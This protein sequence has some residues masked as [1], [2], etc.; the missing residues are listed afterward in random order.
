M[1]DTTIDRNFVIRSLDILEGYK[2]AYSKLCIATKKSSEKSIIDDISY[3]LDS[4]VSQYRE[5]CG[6]IFGDYIEVNPLD[7]MQAKVPAITYIQSLRNYING[8]M[9]DWNDD[10]DS[11]YSY[12][13]SIIQEFGQFLEYKMYDVKGNEIFSEDL[14]N[15]YKPDKSNYMSPLA[16][17][18]KSEWNHK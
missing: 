1:V 9:D 12:I 15:Y 16:S 17:I 2:A 7:V 11:G 8:L 5:E 6:L 13:T 18:S 4:F 3:R 10:V 14:E